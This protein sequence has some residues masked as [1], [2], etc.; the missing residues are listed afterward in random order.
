MIRT[1]QTSAGKCHLDYEYSGTYAGHV[2]WVGRSSAESTVNLEQKVEGK[3]EQVTTARFVLVARDPL[4]RYSY[5][6]GV[7]LT[8]HLFVSN[9]V[10][11]PV[12]VWASRIQ[13]LNKQNYKE[14]S[15]FL[16]LCDLLKTCYL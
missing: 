16:Q 13:I 9:S 6:P 8:Y 12:S 11:D 4:N 5:T 15:G 3:W 7:F 10:P 14:K 1:L 2:T